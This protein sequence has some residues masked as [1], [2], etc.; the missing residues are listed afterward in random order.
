MHGWT[1]DT[2]WNDTGLAWIPT[3]PHM[4]HVDSIAG[5]AS[6]GIA[7][8]LSSITIGVG[9]TMPFQLAGKPGADGEAI[10]EQLNTLW[11]D[12][13]KG[14]VYF[15]PAKF[16]P[17]YAAFKGEG[18]GG[19]QIHLDPKTAPSLVE[20]NFRIMQALGAKQILDAAPD[21]HAM[22]DKC[23][24]SDDARQALQAGERLEPIFERWRAYCEEFKAKR[25]GWLLY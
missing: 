8:E 5:Y 18:C 11:P 24:G 22:F 12:A 19:V 4:P 13:P 25:A 10:A 15:R 9:Y 3:S 16:K 21:R 7:G 1:R 6:T 2:T 17:F 14:S 23:V 20:I